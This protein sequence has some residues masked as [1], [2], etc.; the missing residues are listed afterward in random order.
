MK[1]DERM[2]KIRDDL[3]KFT[4]GCREDMHEPDEQDIEARVVGTELDNAFGST[5]VPEFMTKG[6][7]EL[8]V[9]LENTGTDA[10]FNVNLA[11]LIALARKASFS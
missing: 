10:H 4:E 2:R 5:I 7:Q 9:V 1:V 3:R 11:D 8:V 6:Y